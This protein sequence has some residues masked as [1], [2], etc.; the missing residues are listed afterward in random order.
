MDKTWK[1]GFK[2]L[3]R[4]I[5]NDG[6]DRPGKKGQDNL[7]SAS[8]EK[9]LNAIDSGDV[10]ASDM[11]REMSFEGDMLRGG[12]LGGS[13]ASKTVHVEGIGMFSKRHGALYQDLP[14]YAAFWDDVL[15]DKM[16]ASVYIQE[17][18]Q[19]ITKAEDAMASGF[20]DID[21][22][23]NLQAQLQEFSLGASLGEETAPVDK[24]A[25]NAKKREAFRKE[26]R[27]IR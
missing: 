3:V 24:K 22:Y 11:G 27:K 1:V 17:L 16:K 21:K 23:I 26:E 13:P 19:G 4:E 14:A 18:I 5:V 25:I 15:S 8:T 6:K 7:R 10:T 2:A 12:I 20:A 9:F